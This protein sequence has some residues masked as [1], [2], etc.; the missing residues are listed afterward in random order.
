MAILSL[1]TLVLGLLLWNVAAYAI[2]ASSL[3]G[4]PDGWGVLFGAASLLLALV[5]FAPLALC[6]RR[7]RSE[8]AYSARA[9]S[10]A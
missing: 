7:S 2:D 6:V 4:S 1:L 10:L 9:T 5:L 3:E 8:R